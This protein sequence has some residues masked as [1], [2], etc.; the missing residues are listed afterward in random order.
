MRCRC[1]DFA[2]RDVICIHSGR[3]VGSHCDFEFDTQTALITALVL[4]GRKRLWG[5]LGKEDDI[6]IPWDHVKVIGDDTVLVDY[7][8]GTR[9]LSK[10]G[11]FF[12]N[13]LN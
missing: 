4:P 13:I 1:T 11:T 8:F 12:E 10:K 5:L 9:P 6:T 3:K 2:R 7:D